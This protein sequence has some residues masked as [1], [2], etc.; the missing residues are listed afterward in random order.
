MET[1]HEHIHAVCMIYSLYVNNQEHGN[2]NSEILSDKFKVQLPPLGYNATWS[3]ESC[4]TEIL[5]NMSPPSSELKR[6]PSKK[7]PASSKQ[8]AKERQANLTACIM[9]VGLLFSSEDRGDIFLQK[10]IN[11]QLT[12][13]LYPR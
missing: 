5:R 10:I 1:D 6:K 8:Q 3:I 7:L 12:T 13:Q 2:S 11:F 4:S 9:L